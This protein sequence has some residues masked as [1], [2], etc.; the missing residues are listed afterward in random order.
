MSGVFP[1]CIQEIDLF[2]GSETPLIVTGSITNEPGP[3]SVRIFYLKGYNIRPDFNEVA[4]SDVRIVDD[5]GNEEPMTHVGNGFFETSDT[6]SGVIGR[7]YQIKILLPD[8][9]RYESNPEKLLEVPE[10][11]NVTHEVEAGNVLFKVNYKDTPD[12]ENYYRWRFEGI[13]EVE[14]PYVGNSGLGL[15]VRFSRCYSASVIINAAANCWVKHFDE[16]FLSIGSDELY[17]GE[18]W[19]FMVYQVPIDRKFN[20]GYSGA[21]KQYSLTKEAFEY[22]TAIQKQIGNTGTIFE[23]SNYQIRGNIRSLTDPTE[24]VLGYF[25]ASAV[26]TGRTFIEEY[27]GTFGEMPCEPN[28]VGCRP[29]KCISCLTYGLS[30]TKEKPEYWP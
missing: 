8:E 12:V 4:G 24:A 22:W 20:I 19:D 10:V 28:N 29:I 17:N 21:I 18:S 30:S 6:F 11:R 9:K 14:A 15:P 25:G 2:T 7:T 23:T 26:S 16:G 13:Y 5:I 1:S 3:H 27:Q